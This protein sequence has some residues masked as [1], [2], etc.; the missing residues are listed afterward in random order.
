MIIT[1]SSP[2]KELF[3]AKSRVSSFNFV[4]FFIGFACFL[5]VFSL[6]GIVGFFFLVTF[7]DVFG[8][9]WL[10]FFEEY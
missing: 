1:K 4:V 10:F 5:V 7:V 2:K 6:F 8:S 3:L 9:F